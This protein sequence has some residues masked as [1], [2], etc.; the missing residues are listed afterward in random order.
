MD[1]CE[2]TEKSDQIGNMKVVE[3]TVDINGN[4]LTNGQTIKQPNEKEDIETEKTADCTN[5]CTCFGYKPSQIKWLNI[6]WLILIHCLA[7][8]AL[9]YAMLVPIKF[10][11][12][13]FTAFL[14]VC[15][16][17]G[18][19]V[20]AHRLWAHR[21]FKAHWP[22]K[23]LL[24]VFE[25]MSI[26]GGVFSYARDHRNHHK[27][28]DTDADPKNAKRGFFFAHI[29][30]W[31]VKKK[32]DVI[33]YGKKLSVL[34]LME[35]PLVVFQQKFYFPLV[36]LIAIIFPTLTPYFLWNENLLTSFLLCV[37]LRTVS[38]MHH[39]F[40]VNSIAHII[41]ILTFLLFK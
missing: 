7:V 20:G 38:V 39:L 30:W 11:T 41:G 31:T 25:T 17:F 3:V 26:N 2:S 22:L 19:S 40:T 6:F 21:S 28:V 4:E 24:V 34:D 10:F 8:Y 37:V 33:T 16:G 13:S 14:A 27:F 36:I 5:G 35:D 15:S 18:V 12:V 1:K 32:E 23:L 29:G 9:I